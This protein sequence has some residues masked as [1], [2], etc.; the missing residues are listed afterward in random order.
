MNSLFYYG[1][2]DI[3]NLDKIAKFCKYLMFIKFVTAIIYYTLFR[4]IL[5]AIQHSFTVINLIYYGGKIAEVSGQNDKLLLPD[6]TIRLNGSPRMT[7]LFY[8]TPLDKDPDSSSW[9]I[10]WT[11]MPKIE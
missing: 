6:H 9:F 11:F 7:T 10:K 5:L 8:H 2:N 3:L 4:S 1:D